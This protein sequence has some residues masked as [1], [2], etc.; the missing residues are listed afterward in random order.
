M[1]PYA[2]VYF[3][4]QRL[5]AHGVQE[6]LA[7]L[8]VAVAVALVF[9]VTV[10]ASSL[11]NSAANVV[12]TV[13]GPADLQVHTRGPEGFNDNLLAKVEQLPGV[14]RAAQLLEQPAT[15]I[16]PSGHRVTVTIAGAG[17][18]LAVM[19][20]LS[21]TLPAGILSAE[22]IGLSKTSANQLGI[23]ALN[24]R[25]LPRVTVDLR[26]RAIPLKVSAVLGHEASGALSFAQVAVIP[27]ASLQ[28]LAGLSH[29]I[30]RILV[31]S[32]PGQREA[33]RSELETLVGGR[34][35]V[36]AAN[37]EVS[38]I[39]QALRPSNQ[40]SALFAGLATL[41]GFLFAFNAILLTAPERRAAIADL[42]LDGTK[43]KA[44][45]Q[46][47]AFQALCLGVVSSLAGLLLGYLLALGIFQTSPGYLAQAFTLGGNTVIGAKP[48]VLS[49]AGGILA[50]CL[51]SAIPLQDLR[52]R[53][54]LDAVFAE[55]SERDQTPRHDT[56]RLL[57]II[58]ASL[59][60][61]ATALFA[62]VPSAAI[63]VC[64]LLALAT[65]LAVPLILSSILRASERLAMSND[66]L[67]TLPL[68]I[69]SLR[70]RTWRSLALAA[71]GAVALFGSVA[72]SG[73]QHDLLRGLHGF[74]NAYATD[75]Q[76][77]VVNPGYIPETTSFL[78]D[79]YELR[80]ARVP[81]VSSVHVLQSEFMN[82]A[83]RRI[84]IVARPPG[85]GQGVLR[86]QIVA[87]DFPT[88]R[89]QLGQSGWVAVS[90][91]VAKEQHVGVGQL[92]KLPTPTGITSF[93]IAAL[94]TNFG[95]PGGAVLMSTNDYSHLWATH[96]P[97]G[98]AVDFRPGTNIEH[99]RHTIIA[100][101]GANSG[102]EAI[103]AATWSER[104]DTLAGEGLSQL[105]DISN[106]LI[107]AA[108][109]AMAAALGSGIW[110][111][112]VSLAELLLDGASRQRLR[113]ILLTESLLM[114]SAGCLAGAVVGVYGQF[115]ID[116]YL[117]HITGFPVTSIATLARPIEMFALVM[118]VV[119][120]LVSLPG[121]R[122]SR[123]RPALGLSES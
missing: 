111:R 74:A 121:W 65:I 4:G 56:Q 46:M 45:I 116:S 117:K 33:A 50:T 78:P 108:I 64:V 106:L 59:V 57:F 123:V 44:I 14:R 32:K 38:L 97:S 20:G 17:A 16:G 8:G 77:W 75:A 68:A 115:V 71:T 105:D 31:Q 79:E 27:L 23:T 22:G 21:H 114:L 118:A 99:A 93:R 120:V 100:S 69:E 88:A 35:D 2:L 55:S 30:S 43:R 60:A 80:I 62:F 54:R 58:A 107:L 83:N 109:L 5:R 113:R 15:I 102:L 112:R 53:R 29:R 122:A 76:I 49:L 101:L 91:Q 72:L 7:G 98:L 90:K 81:G 89:T 39:H 36:A 51:A 85:T 37:Q 18:G 61:V 86:T 12:H 66:K 13:A 119:L 42:R 26:G 70:A 95:W 87:G 28:G 73:A 48:V 1:G 47:V 34:L 104:F 92:L 52:R 94:T 96:A 3:Y 40:A 6:L 9:A 25:V 41:L 67:T 19:D 82:M 11:T 84:V 24:S 10:A 63:D 103:T 110:Q